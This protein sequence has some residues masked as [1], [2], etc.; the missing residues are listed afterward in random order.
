M[1]VLITGSAG[2]LGS[3]VVSILR[4]KGGHEIFGIDVK[5]PLDI[6]SNYKRFAKASV[7]D[8]DAMQDIFE[9]AKPD[10]AVHLAFVVN[11]LHDTRREEDVA[12]KGTE[13]FLK[14]CERYNVGKVVMMSSAAAYGAHADNQVP[15]T[16]SSPIRGNKKYSYS[17]LKAMTDDLAHKFIK[18]H[19][20]CAFVILRPCLFIGPNT[21]N[22]F[23]EVFKFP[24]LPQISDSKGVRD[25]PFQFI[26]E[27]DMA[28]CVV[29]CLEK[30]VRGVFNIAA[31]GLV[32]F[33]EAARI[34]GKRRFVLPAWLLYPVS[35]I[36]WLLHLIGSP[37]GQLDFMRYPWIMDNAKMKREIFTPHYT[38][39]E[40]FKEYAKT[41]FRTFRA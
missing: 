22:S 32:K 7:T 36:L 38:S 16:E 27:D 6:T 34:I 25:V 30:D 3:K 41:H 39:V 12:L 2:Y 14:S 28:A 26:H 31:D 1:R 24:I 35:S 19:P 33:S 40:A 13:F 17:Y 20:S 23:F 11:A 5:A 4:R 8:E 10:A 15:L 18:N 21:D 9:T 37:P 29:A